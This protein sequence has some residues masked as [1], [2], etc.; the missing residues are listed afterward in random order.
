TS[1][2]PVPST[3]SASTSAD[4]P[5]E[6]GKGNGKRQTYRIDYSLSRMD[7]VYELRVPRLQIVGGTGTGARTSLANSVSVSPRSSVASANGDAASVAS[8]ST[9]ASGSVKEGKEGPA[10]DEE[11]RALRREIKAWWEGG[12]GSF[13]WVDNA[14]THT[15]NHHRRE[16][17]R[18]VPQGA[19]AAALRGRCIL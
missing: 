5:D 4:G 18:R 6:G 13:G 1:V 11:K 16:H 7:D 17:A 19:A 2:A 15:G 9:S 8:M 12:G 14:N 10:V 3:A